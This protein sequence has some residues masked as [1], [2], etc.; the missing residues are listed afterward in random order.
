MGHYQQARL[1]PDRPLRPLQLKRPPD[2]ACVDCGGGPHYAKDLCKPCYMRNLH[3]RRR[4][5]RNA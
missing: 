5:A 3:Q 1:H 2:F 4:N